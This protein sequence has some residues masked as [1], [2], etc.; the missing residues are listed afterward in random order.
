MLRCCELGERYGG[1]PTAALCCLKTY[2]DGAWTARREEQAPKTRK[3]DTLEGFD[4]PTPPSTPS[5]PC[6]G[7]LEHVLGE[8]VGDLA[9]GPV[10]ELPGGAVTPAGGGS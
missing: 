4:F 1:T 10:V 6:S 2:L 7:A 3:G 8:G 5:F 9:V